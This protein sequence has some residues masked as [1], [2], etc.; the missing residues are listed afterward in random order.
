MLQH[1][2]RSP[3]HSMPR[4]LHAAPWDFGSSQRGAGAPG[5]VRAG[6][7]GSETP[8]SVEIREAGTGIPGSRHWMKQI[9]RSAYGKHP[10]QQNP[11]VGLSSWIL[12]CCRRLWPTGTKGTAPGDPL[13]SQGWD[14]DQD[15]LSRCSSNAQP[16]LASLNL[17]SCVS[18]EVW[19]QG[20]IRTRHRTWPL[21]S[22]WLHHRHD[23]RA[24]N[25]PAIPVTLSPR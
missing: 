18:H 1:Q 11:I 12:C 7:E 17:G 25:L 20:R 23:P 16:H 15:P 24:R 6:N 9:P 14:R 3:L 5:N 2:P 19:E 13:V 8:P 4:L 22:L 10:D 21:W